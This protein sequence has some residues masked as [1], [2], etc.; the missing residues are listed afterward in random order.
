MTSKF[1][2]LI[3]PDRT[4]TLEYEDYKYEVTGEQILAY[5]RRDAFM[6]EFLHS[7]ETQPQLE[8]TVLGM[9]DSSE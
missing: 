8:G 9:S 4:Y 3:F 2:Y 1:R 5:F 6:Q 7:L